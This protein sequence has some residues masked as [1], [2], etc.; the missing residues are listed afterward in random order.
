[1]FQERSPNSSFKQGNFRLG[2]LNPKLYIWSY[3]MIV[4]L[5]C[6]EFRVLHEGNL[7]FGYLSIVLLALL[8]KC[9]IMMEFLY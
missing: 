8:P 9:V 2:E 5:F 1:M 3:C 6:H 4:I 7:G